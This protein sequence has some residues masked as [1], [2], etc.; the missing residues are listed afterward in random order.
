[1]KMVV[2][3]TRIM[4]RMGRSDLG[5]GNTSHVVAQPRARV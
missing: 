5:K 2:I 1:M 4:V 3:T